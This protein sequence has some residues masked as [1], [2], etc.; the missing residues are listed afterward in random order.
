MP[1]MMKVLLI[2]L[3]LFASGSLGLQLMALAYVEN[4]CTCVC[5]QEK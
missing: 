4:P 3:V 5:Q 1:F 2:L